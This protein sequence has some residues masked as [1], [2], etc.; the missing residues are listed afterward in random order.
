MFMTFGY[1][2]QYT[3]K[4]RLRC[5]LNFGIQPGYEEKQLKPGYL[6]QHVS[7]ILTIRI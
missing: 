2:S 6:F 3:E 7:I 1:H 4:F 5:Q